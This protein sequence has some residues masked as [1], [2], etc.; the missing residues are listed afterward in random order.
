MPQLLFSLQDPTVTGQCSDFETSQLNPWPALRLVNFTAPRSLTFWLTVHCLNVSLLHPP[1]SD[2]LSSS[3]SCQHHNFKVMFLEIPA[4]SKAVCFFCPNHPKSFHTKRPSLCAAGRAWKNMFSKQSA[5]RFE[6]DRLIEDPTPGPGAYHLPSAV[7]GKGAILEVSER[8]YLGVALVD[9]GIHMD[10]LIRGQLKLVELNLSLGLFSQCPISKILKQQQLQA[11]PKVR[12]R[13]GGE[14]GEQPLPLSPPFTRTPTPARGRDEKENRVPLSARCGSPRTWSTPA[15]QPTPKKAATPG[16]GW[17]PG[18]ASVAPGCEDRRQ[19]DLR[20]A[21]K[22][23]MV[24]AGLSGESCYSYS[25]CCFYGLV[26]GKK[27]MERE[28]SKLQLE[29][30][31]YWLS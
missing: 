26:C 25:C 5:E 2:L 22:L 29:D 11:I 18:P 31:I 17:T 4:I 14:V 19:R 30:S 9:M 15:T 20:L 13:G 6:K 10:S 23:D 8:W 1:P 28:D 27:V 3:E 16:P 12:K 21:S 24:R 7:D